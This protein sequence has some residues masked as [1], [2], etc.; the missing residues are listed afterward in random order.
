MTKFLNDH[1]TPADGKAKPVVD[2]DEDGSEQGIGSTAQ[3]SYLH[4]YK[5]S[6]ISVN[7]GNVLGFLKWPAS[8]GVND[9]CLNGECEAR[10]PG[11]PIDQH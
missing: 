2:D 4:L 6:P 10:S 9:D 5:Y 7:G 3:L 8:P 1:M 11:L